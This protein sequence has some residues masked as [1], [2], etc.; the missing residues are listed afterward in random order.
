MPSFGDWLR[1]SWED[2]RRRWAIL[3][4][5]AGTGGAA[6]LAAGFLLFIPAALLTVFGVG[7][8]WA[9]WGSAVVVS[10]AAVLW[11]STWAQAAVMR[12]AA[13]DEPTRECLST[14]WG[15]TAAFAWVL[16]LALLSIVG[17][18][19]L[20]ILPG[21]LLSVL[22]F[23][24]PFCQIT[25]EADGARALGLSWARVK[26]H[27]WTVAGRLLAATLLTAAPGWIPYVGWIVM[28]FWAPFSFVAMARLDKDLRA[29]EP[30]A[31]APAWIG[32][33]IAGLTAAFLLGGTA[34]TFAAV[35]VTQ[36]AVREFNA[37][38]GIASR[39]RPETAQALMDAYASQDE[40]R[41]SK[42]MADLLAEV[43]SAVSDTA[44]AAAGANEPVAVSTAAAGTR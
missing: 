40:E 20:L 16:S 1:A 3:L 34:A 38:G 24:A 28:M 42:A 23:A 29:A 15:Q 19:I 37:P 44:A 17:G 12:A 7:P 43:K 14:A 5:V 13:T 30:D 2:F 36:A 32:S 9:V 21:L 6:T 4:A 10:L 27:F 11:L 33:A 22:L 8:A 26:P 41:K 25:G 18:Y 39:L 35:R 31:E